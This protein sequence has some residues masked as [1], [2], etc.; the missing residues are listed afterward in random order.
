MSSRSDAPTLSPAERDWRRLSAA[1]SFEEFGAAWLALAG[2]RLGATRGVLVAQRP[3]SARYAPFAFLPEGEPCGAFL[4]DAAE[5]ALVDASPVTAQDGERFGIALP[6]E[7]QGRLEAIAALEWQ[8]RPR[9]APEA[10]QQDLRWGLAWIEARLA[11]E[12]GTQGTPAAAGDFRAWDLLRGALAA[13][14][15]EDAARAAA[16]ELAQALGCEL[17]GVAGKGAGGAR[18]LALSHTAWFD[19]RQEMPRAIEAALADA[20]A[21]GAALERDIAGASMLCLPAGGFAFAFQSRAPLEAE[22]RRR[23]EAAISLLAPILEL[24][25]GNAEPLARKALDRGKAAAARWV[26][27]GAG[28]RRIGVA[29]AALIAVALVFAEGG[30]RAAGNATLEGSVRRAMTAP[31]DGFVAASHARAGDL[32]KKDAPI[33][34]LDDRDIRLERVRAASQYA[35]YARQIQES[36]AKHDRS[37][38]QILQAQQAQAEAQMQLTDEQLKRARLTAPFDG[39]VVSGDLSQAIGGSVKK[40]EKLFEIAPLAGYRVAIQVDETEIA[41]VRPGQKG[42]LLLAAITERSFPMT[43]TSVTPVAQVRDGRNAF[44]VEAALDEA[45]A[46]EFA[47]LRPGMEGVAKIEAGSRNLVWIWTHRFT[48]WA[49]LQLWSLWP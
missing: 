30:F 22:V 31:F 5:R 18:L 38:V 19:P 37:Q 6:I 1:V 24:Q 33:A 36:L 13:R 7:R 15:L 29:A 9:L 47:R 16:T 46:A 3:G 41:A 35:Q 2:A 11:K 28:L 10:L 48:N 12:G 23:A 34:T 17:V 14:S 32:V 20:L 42:T 27:P 26:G 39:L 40:G 21:G 8:G 45:G 49:R 25:R 44:R 43:V 4:A